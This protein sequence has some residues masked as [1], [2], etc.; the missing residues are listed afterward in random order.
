MYGSLL[1]ADPGGVLLWAG[2]TAFV[3]GL[4]RGFAG[5]GSAILMAPIFA[6]LLGPVHMV[7]M[8][9]AIELPMSVMLFLGSQKDVEWKFVAPLSAIAMA[10]M[11]VGLWLLVSLD[12]AAITRAVSVIVLLFVAVLITGWRYQGP[13]PLALTLGIGGISGAMMATTSVGGPPV[14]LY[15]LAAAMPAATIRANIVAYYLLTG[16]I[17][18]TM[19]MLASPTALA[20][21]IDAMVLLPV[22]LASS[23]I[24]SRLA[25]KAA[26]QTYRWIAYIFLAAA[27]IIGLVG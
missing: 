16:F 12:A 9:A 3:A 18:V 4:M 25:G 1:L 5:F 15:M 19:V 26:D 22:I 27:G 6:V 24:G 7:P 2:I 14:L 8:V 23:W 17:L 21:V 20:A 10:A 13:R 11:P